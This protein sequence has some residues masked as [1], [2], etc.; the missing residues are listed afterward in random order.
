MCATLA[1][2][3]IHYMRARLQVTVVWADE[4]PTVGSPGVYPC[5]LDQDGWKGNCRPRMAFRRLDDPDPRVLVLF[6]SSPS[7]SPIP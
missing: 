1:R 2:L 7:T 4:N 3:R 5:D 6:S